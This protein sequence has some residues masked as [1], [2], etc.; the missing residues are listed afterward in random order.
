MRATDY[1]SFDKTFAPRLTNASGEAY[2]AANSPLCDE[3]L[4]DD[5]FVSTYVL[6]DVV[7][8]DSVLK[9]AAFSR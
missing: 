6:T 5:Y 9:T 1:S 2:T 3:Y 8:K 7:L 4:N